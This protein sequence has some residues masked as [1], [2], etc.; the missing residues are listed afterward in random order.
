MERPFCLQIEPRDVKLTL[1]PNGQALC[2]SRSSPTPAPSHPDYCLAISHASC[3]A[4]HG[5]QGKASHAEHII[6][7]REKNDFTVAV[8][9][10]SPPTLL[11]G[12]F[13]RHLSLHSEHRTQ[14][15]CLQS[16]TLQNGI[17]FRVR[18]LSVL[19]TDNHCYRRVVLQAIL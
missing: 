7:C 13:S 12:P 6:P 15:T 17:V 1:L 18:R 2:K 10:T 5:R 19:A 3:K 4:S 11:S 14:P 16:Q 9:T 8:V